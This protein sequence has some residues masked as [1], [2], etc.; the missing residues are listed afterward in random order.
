MPALAADLMLAFPT[1]RR[2]PGFF[3]LVV[4]TLALGTGANMAILSLVD[5]VLL[6]PRPVRERS[7]W[8][9]CSR[10]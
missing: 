7:A 2:S 3:L 6:R 8:W 10:R 5:A 9:R 1:L 4:V